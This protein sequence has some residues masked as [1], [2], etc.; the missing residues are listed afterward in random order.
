MTN[1]TFD[2]ER[3]K[4]I[5]TSMVMASGAAVAGSGLLGSAHAQTPAKSANAGALAS[6]LDRSP[7]K[8][9]SLEVSS[10]GLGVQNMAALIRRRSLP[11]PR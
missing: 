3:R 6:S 10:I 11:G 9:R 5:S 4:F 8:A 2:E 1:P 7:A